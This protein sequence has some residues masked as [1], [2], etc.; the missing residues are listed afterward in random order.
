[1]R[2]AYRRHEL[3]SLVGFNGDFAIAIWDVT[4]NRLVLARD[5]FGARPLYYFEDRERLIFAS[6]I[7]AILE[8]IGERPSINL[9]LLPEYLMFRYT[10]GSETLLEGIKEVM[11]G[12]HI[13]WKGE[14]KAEE[15]YWRP[16]E[17]VEKGPIVSDYSDD[18]VRDLFKEAV[19]RRLNFGEKIGANCSGG[20]DSGLVTVFASEILEEPFDSYTIGF[21]ERDWDERYY[22]GL[23]AR[24]ARTVHHEF[25]ITSNE[26]SAELPSLNWHNDE[27]LSDPNSVLVY[28]LAKHSKDSIDILLTG[29]GADEV[30]LGYPRYNL[31]N[32]YSLLYAKPSF[33]RSIAS[34]GFS[35]SGNRRLKKLGETLML[36]PHDAIIYNSA[37]V[38]EKVIAGLLKPEIDGQ[39]LACRRDLLERMD[40][41]IDPLARL[42]L[43]ECQT[44]LL[45]SLKRLDKM[46]MIVG[47][48]TTTPFLDNDYFDFTLRIPNRHKIT[49]INNKCALRRVASRVLPRENMKMPKSGFGVPIA[50]WFRTDSTLQE[51]LNGLLSDSD[52]RQLFRRKELNRV[53]QG[54]MNEQFDNSEILWLLTNFYLWYKQFATG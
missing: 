34:Y 9:S 36:D 24:K 29:E 43:Y 22:A 48:E 51:L 49:L 20:I 14:A 42:M 19:R 13:V 46:N 25:E 15:Q 12:Q 40:N 18:R 1:V 16:A 21:E 5:R 26:F 3:S 33:L 7:K 28:I 2:D 52:M 23:T 4:R 54:H 6:E 37:F 41:R 47:L 45:S 27:P 35:V 38:K 10:F 17:V 44:Y 50:K 32:L 11:P 31:F 53:I 30:S 8:I 39:F